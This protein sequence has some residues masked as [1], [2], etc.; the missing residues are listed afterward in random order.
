MKPIKKVLINK[1]K[2]FAVRDTSRD[3]HTQYGFFK[4]TDLK[5]KAGTKI[6]SNKGKE[7]TVLDPSFID[8]YKKIKRGAQIVARKEVGLIIAETGINKNSKV[9]DAGAGSG[10]LCLMLANIAKSVVT[11]EIREDFYKLVK[12]NIEFLGLKNIKIKNKDITKGI[13]EK[14]IDLITLDL[15]AP[16]EA[17]EHA[18]KALKPG[19]F[20]VSY[21]PTIPQVMDFVS[22]IK[23]TKDFIY[24]DS[25]ELLKR[26]WEVEDRK[27]RPMSRMTG[28][29]GFL[30]FARK[31]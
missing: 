28:H 26:G 31:I 23:K 27:V 12:G 7:F 9:V 1:D 18:S 5:K 14:N 4:S 22:A 19:G 30:S 6:K 24:I 10:A 3:L 29:T 16:W 20:L 25:F 8:C 21:S 2:T 17:I 13:S 11:Y 15:P